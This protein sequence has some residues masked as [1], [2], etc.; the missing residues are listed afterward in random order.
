M[1][2]FPQPINWS[3]I[4]LVGLLGRLNTKICYLA[5]PNTNNHPMSDNCNY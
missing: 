3:N 2:Q 5:V 1:S 4:N